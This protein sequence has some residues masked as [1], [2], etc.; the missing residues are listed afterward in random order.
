MTNTQERLNRQGKDAIEALHN[1]VRSIWAKMCEVD[2]IPA[3]SSFVIFSDET[4][5]KYGP[6]YDQALSQLNEARASYRVGGYVG[7][8]VVNG[9]AK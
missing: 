7:L 3:D 4:N 6:F 5:D 8:R 9:K 1:T 2:G